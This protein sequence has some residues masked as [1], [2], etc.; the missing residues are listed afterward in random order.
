ML[1]RWLLRLGVCVAV[2]VAVT[3]AGPADR[4]LALISLAAIA[5]PACRFPTHARRDR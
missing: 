5:L 2:T 1:R 3:F 4:A